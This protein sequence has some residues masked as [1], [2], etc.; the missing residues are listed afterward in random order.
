MNV[1]IHIRPQR[2]P[3]GS[4]TVKICVTAGDSQSPNPRGGPAFAD[5]SMS[6]GPD[7]SQN[8]ATR[9]RIRRIRE[10]IRRILREIAHQTGEPPSGQIIFLEARDNLG[11]S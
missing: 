2:G 8:R 1:T 3:D 4:E 7:N 6:F 9:C 5:R 11:V 10:E